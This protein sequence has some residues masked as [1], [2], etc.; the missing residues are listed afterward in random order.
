MLS[1]KKRGAAAGRELSAHSDETHQLHSIQTCLLLHTLGNAL[2]LQPHNQL[3]QV[4][5]H[6]GRA[7]FEKTY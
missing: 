4:P 2:L 7:Q 5:A 1:E 6:A 3:Q